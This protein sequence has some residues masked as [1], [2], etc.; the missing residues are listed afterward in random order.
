[1]TRTLY[2]KSY[3]LYAEILEYHL[4]DGKFAILEREKFL[5]LGVPMA[6]GAF[7]REGRQVAGLFASPEGPV[8]FLDSQHVVGRFGDTSATV[9][10]VS[11]KKHFTLSHKRA[12]GETVEFDLL[13]EPRLGLGANPYDNEEEDIDLLAMI[14][15]NIGHEAFFRAYTKEWAGGS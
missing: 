2:L 8:F 5:A 15:T 13:Y 11:G 3:D 14:A 7:C 9:K 10:D 6:F 4:L 12:T 1:M